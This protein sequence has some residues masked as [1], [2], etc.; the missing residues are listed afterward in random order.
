[1]VNATQQVKNILLTGATGVLGSRILLEI[2]L[3][4]D[5]CVYCLV[6]AADPQQAMARLE[7]LLYTYDPQ[8]Q[9]REQLWRVIPLLGDITQPQLGLE[10]SVYQELATGIE[11]VIHCAANV[12]LVASYGKI[13]PVNVGGT[14]NLIALC[15]EDDVPLLYT[16]SFSIVGDKLYQE[17]F[18]LQETDLDVG[19]SFKDMDY[20]RSKF[21][22]EQAVHQAGKQG[23][24]W[25]ITRPGNIW[26][27]SVTGRYPLVET[28]V[29]GIYYE[30]I[31]ALV[32]TGLTFS[33]REDFDITPVDYVARA[34]LHAILEID[35]FHG[36]TLNLTNPAPV[37]YDDIVEFLRLYGYRINTLINSDYFE[38]LTENR[39]WLQGKPYRS[40]FTD[41]LALFYCGSEISEKARYGTQLTRQLLADAGIVCA[42]CDRELLFRYF[43]YLTESGFVVAPESQGAAAEVR[44]IVRQ[45]GFLE[46]LYDADLN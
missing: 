15:L 43:S 16:S 13:A 40:T 17:G 29:K 12:S 10:A 41:L 33:S 42:P 36:A 8:Q 19:Q 21:E 31:K 35:T 1:M 44:E 20:E 9:C 22:A 28:R 34:S 4:S 46:Q 25:V 30:M 24:R 37:T 5:A 18:T 23:L 7:Q 3:Q 6:R 11:R 2:L 32:E 26:G 14:R 27:D 38:A 39:I 45:G